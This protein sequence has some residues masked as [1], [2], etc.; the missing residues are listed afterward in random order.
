MQVPLL[1]LTLQKEHS[2]LGQSCS[3]F[4]P[5]D[6]LNTPQCCTLTVMGFFH[7]P[8][9]IQV[10]LWSLFLIV[11]VC[12]LTPTAARVTCRHRDDIIF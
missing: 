9:P 10:D 7:D 12:T 11:G 8:P 5:Q 1:F 2:Q 4:Q 3:Q 6:K